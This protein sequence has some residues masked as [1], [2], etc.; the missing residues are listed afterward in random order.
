VHQEDVAPKELGEL[1]CQLAGPLR[2]VRPVVGNDDPPWWPRLLSPAHDEDRAGGV[3]RGYVC[4]AHSLT[5]Q[6]LY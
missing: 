4:W 3:V 1:R 5:A 6:S 2:C